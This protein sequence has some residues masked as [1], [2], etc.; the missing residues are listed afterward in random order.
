MKTNF[1]IQR[2]TDS[3]TTSHQIYSYI[4]LS[5]EEVETVYICHVD[6]SDVSKLKLMCE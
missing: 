4:D 3:V 5:F 1:M 2:L 6:D